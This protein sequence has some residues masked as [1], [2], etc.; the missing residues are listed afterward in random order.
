MISLCTVILE[1]M[2]VFADILTDC[3]LKRMPSV[4][5]MIISHSDKEN[6][7]IDAY[8]LERKDRPLQIIES[9]C[10][11]L[12]NLDFPLG[13]IK[14]ECCKLKINLVTDYDRMRHG[15]AI[16]LHECLKFANQEYILFSEPDAFYYSD[17][18]EVYIEIMNKYDI[19]FIGISPHTAQNQSYTYFPCVQS[20][21]VRKDKLPPK[22]WLKNVKYSDEL[23]ETGPKRNH[24]LLMQGKYLIQSIIPE[25][26]NEFPNSKGMFDTG[27]LLYL[28]C[29]QQGMR[30]LSFQTLDTK[31]WT[32]AIYKTN[33]KLKDK[34]K[35][36]K[37]LYHEG[38]GYQSSKIPDCI[39]N[40]KKLYK[41]SYD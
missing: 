41:E 8:A 39:K 15:H 12:N 21:V 4:E 9:N 2:K 34:L 16:G 29:K 33:F 28:W 18:A 13:P 26:K 20:M 11:F 1:D 24:E 30:W 37:I 5:E 17:P 40:Y 19:D 22:D 31:N 3:A 23:D 10:N 6:L 32:T 25:F 14:E 7:H 27:C 36:K 35:R 38:Q